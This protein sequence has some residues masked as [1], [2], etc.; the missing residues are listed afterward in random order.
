MPKSYSTVKSTIAAI[1]NK[2]HSSNELDLDGLL[3]RKH[4]KD[5]L[6]SIDKQKRKALLREL[7]KC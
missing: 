6:E 1:N 7:S 2:M 5:T 4:L 3:M